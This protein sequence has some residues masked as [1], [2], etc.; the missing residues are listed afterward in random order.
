MALEIAGGVLPRSP[1]NPPSQKVAQ[2][3]FA[4]RHNPIHD[5]ESV[6]WLLCWLCL[7][8]DGPGQ[9]R[10]ILLE[11]GDPPTLRDRPKV[12]EPFSPDDFPRIKAQVANAFDNIAMEGAQKRLMMISRPDFSRQV[13]KNMAPYFVPLKV[14]LIELRQVL[15]EAYFEDRRENIHDRF[16]AVLTQAAEDLESRP[17]GTDGT[18]LVYETMK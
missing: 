18:A 16:L 1:G 12:V 17:D 3:S 2:T 13:L 7:T 11:D 10:R 5:L 6:F 9:T 14:L 15:Y 8:R 4:F